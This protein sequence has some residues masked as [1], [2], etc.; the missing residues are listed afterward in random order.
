[1]KDGNAGEY[2]MWEGEPAQIIGEIH[3]RAVM[4]QM[5]ESSRCPHCGGDLEKES[6]AVIVASPQYQQGAKPLKTIKDDDSLTV[7]KQKL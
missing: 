4:I 3:D 7:N 2:L 1:M 5:L 6:F